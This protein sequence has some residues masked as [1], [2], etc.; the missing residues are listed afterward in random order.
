MQ[1]RIELCLSLA[2][3]AHAGQVDKGGAPYIEFDYQ[4]D[5]HCSKTDRDRGRSLLEFDYQ[6]DRHCSKTAPPL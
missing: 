2:S 6:L 1:S 4:L 3:E 5:R